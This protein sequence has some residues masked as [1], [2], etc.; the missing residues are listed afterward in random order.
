MSRVMFHCRHKS[1]APRSCQEN[2]EI[3]FTKSKLKIQR[4]NIHVLC[5]NPLKLSKKRT[6]PEMTEK[7][8]IRLSTDLIWD[9]LNHSQLKA[10]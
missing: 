2:A 6:C 3:C 5:I 10:A 8:L 1:R 4:G 7:L 9:F